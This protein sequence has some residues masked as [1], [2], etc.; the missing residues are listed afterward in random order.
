MVKK[1]VIG[2][3]PTVKKDDINP[4]EYKYTYLNSYSKMITNLGAVPFGLLLNDKK[5]N[6]HS[7]NMCNGFIIPGGKSLERFHFTIILYALKHNKPILGICLGMQVL[8]YFSILKDILIN[9]NIEVNEDSLWKVYEKI[10]NEEYFKLKDIPIPNI[11]GYEIMN[12]LIECN[13]DN[14]TKSKH[15]ISINKDSIL[16]QIYNKDKISVLSLHLKQVTNVGSDFY[17]SAKS[18][19]NIIEALEYKDKSYFIIGVQYHPE[20]DD[21]LLFKYFLSEVEKRHV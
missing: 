17:V 8:N 12:S 2:I 13:Y 16:Y 15:D 1:M 18:D 14:L 9:R 11:H 19:D 21:K 4:Y 20:L 7:L 6:E 3:V 10:K 5:I